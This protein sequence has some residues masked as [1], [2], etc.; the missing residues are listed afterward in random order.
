[1]TTPKIK[2]MVVDDSAVIRGLLTRAMSGQADIEIIASASNGLLAVEQLKK[3]QPDVITLDVEMPHM[4]GITALPE[5]LKLAPHTRVIMVSTLTHRNAAI[6][7]K[8]LG[9][10]ASDYLAKPE[11]N[12]EQDL[13]SFFR[14]LLMKVRAL[15]PRVSAAVTAPTTTSAKPSKPSVASMPA[16]PAAASPAAKVTVVTSYPKTPVRALAIGSSTGG[17]QALTTLFKALATGFP[18]VPVFITQH[19]PPTFTTILAEHIQQAS[20]HPCAEGKQGE[21]VKAGSIYLA[22]GNFH[23]QPVKEDGKVIIKLN[24]NP[25]V[26]FCRPAVDPMLQSL[27][28]IYG[29]GLL[30]VILTGMGSDGFGGCKEVVASGGTV[31][32]QNEET[33]V[34]WGMPKAVTEGNLCSAVLP[35]TD[36]APYITRAC[37]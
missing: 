32:A 15:A 22:P 30:T 5:I 26:N 12:G 21:E 6:S 1:M 37:S 2:V 27:I 3:I 4:D 28:Q 31:V 35:L 17:P 19:M 29:G 7:V 13:E 11:V 23:M 10:G 24:Q 9:L 36:I 16:S 8:A 33:C 34:V 25:Q 20:G 18:K 14:E